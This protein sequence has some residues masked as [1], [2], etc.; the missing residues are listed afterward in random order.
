MATA[1]GIWNHANTGTAPLS[2]HAAASSTSPTDSNAGITSNDFLTLLVS[3]LKNQD[4]T[5]QTDPNA[6]VTQLVQVN[7][8]Q[9]LISIN[10]TLNSS[11]GAAGQSVAGAGNLQ[12][13]GSSGAAHPSRQLAAASADSPNL[14]SA[15]TPSPLNRGADG[16][17]QTTAGNLGVPIANPAASRVAHA[18]DG[19]SR[20]H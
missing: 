20:L 12:R 10:Q 7:S 15:L 14:T 11:V 6:Y 9:Q 5:A 8:L 13:A 1:S 2:T 18:L 3:E 19:G 4:P 16:T 17:L